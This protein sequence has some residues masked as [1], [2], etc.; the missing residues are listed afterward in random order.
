M[1]SLGGLDYIGPDSD[2]ACLSIGLDCREAEPEGQSG[3][4]LRLSD[5]GSPCL[6]TEES[7]RSPCGSCLMTMQTIFPGSDEGSKSKTT[8]GSVGDIYKVLGKW[9]V[10]GLVI[11]I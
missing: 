10:V 5:N 2:L 8:N 3:G 9:A 4:S 7:V 6:A 1:G 11:D